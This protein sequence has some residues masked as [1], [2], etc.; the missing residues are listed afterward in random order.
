LILF[1][2]PEPPLY[3]KVPV[4]AEA[5]PPAPPAAEVEA[6]PPTAITELVLKEVEP[7]VPDAATP[8]AAMANGMMLLR[9]TEILGV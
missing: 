4:Q 2:V 1:P 7:P 3:A 5:R 9:D 8:P 6:T